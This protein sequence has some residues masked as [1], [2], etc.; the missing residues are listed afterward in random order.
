MT[1]EEARI[2]ELEEKIAKAKDKL[3]KLRNAEKER[4]CKGKNFKLLIRFQLEFN[5][6]NS[7]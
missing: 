2:E 4:L 3:S 7:D 5:E 1:E 6:L